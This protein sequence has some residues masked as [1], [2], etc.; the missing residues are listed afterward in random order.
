MPAKHNSSGDQHV[1]FFQLIPPKG[2]LNLKTHP[3]GLLTSAFRQTINYLKFWKPELG[4]LINFAEADAEIRRV[5]FH[6]SPSEPVENYDH[7]RG[8][9]SDAVREKLVVEIG[10]AHV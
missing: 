3:D 8:Q 6:E 2:R 10:R 5:V 7:I 9:M 4:L 1:R